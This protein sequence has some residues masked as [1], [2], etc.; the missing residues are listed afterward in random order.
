MHLARGGRSFLR[1]S[2]AHPFAVNLPASLFL[3]NFFFYLGGGKNMTKVKVTRL[4]TYPVKSCKG[5]D[6]KQIAVTETGVHISC[7]L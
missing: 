4:V 3:R 7:T 1:L 5:I 6:V 2:E